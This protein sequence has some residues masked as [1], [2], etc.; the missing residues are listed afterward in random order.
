MYQGNIIFL[1]GDSSIREDLKRLNIGPQ[2]ATVCAVTWCVVLVDG[3]IEVGGS[4]NVYQHS[5]ALENGLIKLIELI[6][7]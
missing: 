4:G 7:T 1:T 6:R 5:R 3:S 2:R